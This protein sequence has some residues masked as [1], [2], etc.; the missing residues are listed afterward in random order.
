MAVPGAKRSFDRTGG[1]EDGRPRRSPDAA[2][3]PPP[4]PGP[5]Q[6]RGP[7]RRLR[8]PGREPAARSG[9]RTGRELS[10]RETASRRVRRRRR[11][12]RVGAAAAR[13][14]ASGGVRSATL[15][16]RS[17]RSG[18][19]PVPE[20]RRNPSGERQCRRYRAFSGV[21]L[22]AVLAETAVACTGSWNPDFLDLDGA[23]LAQR[24]CAGL[25]HPPG[26]DRILDR[27]G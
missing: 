19:H 18:P 25:G 6:R 4:Q 11:P 9:S 5:R 2:L 27:A 26:L 16:N 22:G 7:A 15:A 17:G 1:E 14:R 23:V 20:V 8:P 13:G 24:Q 3:A 12:G 21:P 10:R